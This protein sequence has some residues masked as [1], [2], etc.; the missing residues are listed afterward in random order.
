MPGIRFHVGN[1][2]RTI[3]SVA[4]VGA[5]RLLPARGKKA[6]FQPY[7][8]CDGSARLLTQVPDGWQV[9]AWRVHRPD[10]RHD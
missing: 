9:I 5:D 10:V 6:R 7:R 2:S 3:R 4:I 1:T 8:V